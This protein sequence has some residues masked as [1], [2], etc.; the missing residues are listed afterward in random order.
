[1]PFSPP[2]VASDPGSQAHI[3]AAL[4]TTVSFIDINAAA[5]TIVATGLASANL[6]IAA[7]V[8]GLFTA[9]SNIALGVT[10]LYTANSNIAAGVTALYTANSNISAA[11]TDV[12]SLGDAINQLA[13]SFAGGGPGQGDLVTRSDLQP[14]VSVL[15]SIAAAL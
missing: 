2:T 7:G 5:V 6:N 8:T 14:L 12:T 3:N 9:N 11:A 10:G 1:M 15:R 13:N 4:A